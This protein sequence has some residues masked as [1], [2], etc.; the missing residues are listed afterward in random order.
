[1]KAAPSTGEQII[2]DD[3]GPADFTKIQDAIDNATD[4]DNILVSAGRYN[5]TLLIEK[6]LT[7]VGEDAELTFIDGNSTGTVIS[8]RETSDVRIRGFT[9]QNSG[10]SNGNNSGIFIF[11]SQSCVISDS[12]FKDTYFAI[13]VHSSSDTLI[14]NNLITNSIEGINLEIGRAGNILLNNTLTNNDYGVSLRFATQ[15]KILNNVITGN[16]IGIICYSSTYNTIL[17]NEISSNVLNGIQFLNS[18]Y[19]SVSENMIIKNRGGIDLYVSTSNSIYRNNFNN[20]HTQTESDQPNTWDDGIEGNYWSDYSGTDNNHDGIGDT[21]Y[22]ITAANQEEPTSQDNYPLMGMIHSIN[23]TTD[24]ETYSI[25]S[26]S[27]SSISDFGYEI[28][29][30]TG[31]KIVNLNVSGRDDTTG[32]CRIAI[33]IDL[34]NYSI[35]VLFD[36]QEIIPTE[37]NITTGNHRYLYFTYPHSKHTIRII[38]SETRYLHERYIELNIAYL[39]LLNNYILLS[40]NNSKLQ[41]Q[42]QELNNSHYWHLL[43]YNQLYT[44]YMVLNGSHFML[45]NDT[46]I[47]QINMGT[48]MDNYNKLQEQYQELNNSYQELESKYSQDTQ[49]FRNLI[50]SFAATTA[51]FIVTTVYLSKQAHTNKKSTRGRSNRALFSDDEYQA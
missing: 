34:M 31:N 46:A 6:R 44:E 47:L 38:S 25:F 14:S 22:N 27:N 21:P 37:L 10:T 9:I 48:L 40:E 7:L 29:P 39:E 30:E 15:V 5:E 32:F 28:G 16:D 4:G 18:R 2:V 49:N 23:V 51:F 12:I 3:D 45:L 36:Q 8:I 42:Y 19:N 13:N 24:N 17:R 26:I 11:N 1:L 33:P 41:E 50:Y 43:D 20:T 35:I